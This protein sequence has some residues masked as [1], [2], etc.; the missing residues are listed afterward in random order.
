MEPTW[1]SDWEQWE[2]RRTDSVM[3]AE[4]SANRLRAF[5]TFERVTSVFYLRIVGLNSQSEANKAANVP[6]RPVPAGCFYTNN[7]ASSRTGCHSNPVT[8]RLCTLLLLRGSRG[9]KREKTAR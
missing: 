1:D 6:T 2:R 3:Q 5:V 8:M 9:T 4:V 7:S